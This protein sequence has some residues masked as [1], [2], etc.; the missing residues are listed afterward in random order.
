MDTGPGD[1]LRQILVPTTHSLISG[2]SEC[3]KVAPFHHKQLP[4]GRNFT[5]L[6]DPGINQCSINKWNHLIYI[7]YQFIYLYIM[8][9]LE[10]IAFFVWRQ[11]DTKKPLTPPVASAALRSWRW[12]PC[13]EAKCAK[14]LFLPASALSHIDSNGWLN[15]FGGSL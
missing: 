4:K 14:S 12:R 5:Y 7:Y 13:S 9:I 11:W 8:N 3:V 6:E 2:S 15:L 10:L 1:H